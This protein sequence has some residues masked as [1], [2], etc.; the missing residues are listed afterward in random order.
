MGTI[1]PSHAI[2]SNWLLPP[3]IARDLFAAVCEL[4][5]I[6]VHS[7]VDANA[8]AANHCY[9]SLATAWVTADPYKH[10][11]MRLLGV[12][13][14]FI[15]GDAPLREKFQRWAWAFPRLIGNPLHD[16]GRL[17]LKRVFG[18]DEWLEPGSAAR[19]ADTA[20]QLL[21]QPSHGARALLRAAGVAAVCTSDRLLDDLSAHQSLVKTRH[22]DDPRLIPSL[23]GDD[24]LTVGEPD[25]VGWVHALADSANHP[26][27]DYADFVSAVYTHLDRFHR[28][29][30][31]VADHGI[32]QLLT[33]ALPPQDATASLFDTWL[34]RGELTPTRSS[35]LKL[36]ILTMLGGA[37]RKRGWTLLLHLGAQR[38]TSSRLRRLAG[39]A[40]GYATV[41]RAIDLRTLVAWLDHLEQAEALPRT[42]LFNS[43]PADNPG[44]ATLPGSFAR[45]DEPGYVSWG[46][47]WWYN[48]HRRGIES[49]L[50]VTADH[51][52]LSI[53]PGMASDSRSI[54]SM[55]RHEY[56]RRVMCRWLSRQVAEQR[57]PD[58]LDALV[59]L[60]RR[61]IY[62][63]PARILGLTTENPPHP[64][65]LT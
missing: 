6:D 45:D 19:I 58:D 27:R 35:Q 24:L 21:A 42:I 54:L 31:R 10:R 28:L 63:N 18:I 26:I 25:A 16:W 22:P 4:P 47:A 41:G 60:S 62:E 17:E 40:G 7:H 48:D 2:D 34:Q 38:A 3:G 36:G 52:L 51:S 13:E 14:R 30:T 33:S 65:G 49:H 55:H 56:F 9:N 50:R 53:F 46:P 1:T 39:Q 32:D 29:G 23:R 20:R 57:M 44:F 15:T 11:A 59:D 64:G 8:V 61:M 43:N 37:Y 12:P 5:I